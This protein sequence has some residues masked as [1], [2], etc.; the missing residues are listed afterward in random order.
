MHAEQE[1]LH[2]P[3]SEDGAAGGGGETILSAPRDGRYVFYI[4]LQQSLFGNGVIF[5]LSACF[6]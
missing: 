1:K 4:F 6:I 2:L 3:S 5:R